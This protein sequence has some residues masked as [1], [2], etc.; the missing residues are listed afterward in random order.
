[1]EDTAKSERL[2]RNKKAQ[3]VNDPQHNRSLS[4]SLSQTAALAYREAQVHFTRASAAA[5]TSLWLAPQ[6]CSDRFQKLHSV[7][8]RRDVGKQ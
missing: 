6:F 5:S 2:K 8:A 4:L 3:P 7:R 1:M